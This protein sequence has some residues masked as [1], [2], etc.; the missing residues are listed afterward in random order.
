VNAVGGVLHGVVEEVEDGGA[1]VFEVAEDEEANAAGDVCKGD[2]FGLEVV[3]NKYC[4][5]A[6]GDEGMELD[7]GALL[8]ALALAEFAGLEDGFD[9]GEETVAVFAHDGVEALSLLLIAGVALESFEV[10]SDA[11][12]GSL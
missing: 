6:V 2:V 9:G 4:C 5:D 12:D 8:D 3:A 1:E 10:E 11:G 7:A